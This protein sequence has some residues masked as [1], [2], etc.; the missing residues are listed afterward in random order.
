MEDKYYKNLVDLET[1]YNVIKK[2]KYDH[3]IDY[4]G[5]APFPK[6]YIVILKNGKRVKFGDVR[7]EDYLIHKD[8]KRRELYHKRH[9][10]NY[11]NPE[12]ASFWANNV[13]W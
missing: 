3:L 4:I 10:P 8:E 6:K 7:Y 5:Y 13:L 12:K 2:N 11:N 9:K 1:L